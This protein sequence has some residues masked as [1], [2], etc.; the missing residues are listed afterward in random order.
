MRKFN[1]KNLT[2]Y[3]TWWDFQN[4][5]KNGNTLCH[6]TSKKIENCFMLI[7]KNVN[8]DDKNKFNIEYFMN[9]RFT[10]SLNYKYI[11]MKQKNLYYNIYFFNEII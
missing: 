5:I 9:S 6:N 4:I 10:F 3:K 2:V 7:L 8:S 1:R 11:Y